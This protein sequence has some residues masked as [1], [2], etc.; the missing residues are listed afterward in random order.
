MT[1][2]DSPRGRVVDAGGG[3]GLRLIGLGIIGLVLIVLLF[4]SIT[5]V[6]TG[7]VGVRETLGAGDHD[8]VV[9]V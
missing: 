8:E 6:G 2:F 5:R 3:A 9:W 7:H 1:I 4:N